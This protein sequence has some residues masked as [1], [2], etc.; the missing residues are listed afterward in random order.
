M[1]FLEGNLGIQIFG[2][3]PP[4]SKY[5]RFVGF[6]DIGDNANL[7]LKIV[8][9][10]Q[11]DFQ[12]VNFCGKILNLF[13]L[14][15]NLLHLAGK[16]DFSILELRSRFSQVVVIVYN[17]TN[18][19]KKRDEDRPKQPNGSFGCADLFGGRAATAKYNKRDFLSHN[20]YTFNPTFGDVAPSLD[21]LP[22]TVAIFGTGNF[23]KFQIR[24]P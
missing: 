14:K 24:S 13:A 11:L 6:F 8:Q 15:S 18:H 19:N 16:V 4:H 9:C 7:F 5:T 20:Q 23:V 17:I 2:Y 21:E 22:Q 1:L 3:G 10:Q 12:G